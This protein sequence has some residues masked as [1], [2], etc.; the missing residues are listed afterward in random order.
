MG[1]LGLV[2]KAE[3]DVSPFPLRDPVLESEFETRIVEGAAGASA[4]T[5][6][7]RF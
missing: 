3:G 2:A 5:P 7:Q 4:D 1:D 6:R